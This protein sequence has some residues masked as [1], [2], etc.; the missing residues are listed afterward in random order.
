M[1]TFKYDRGMLLVGTAGINLKT[2][3]IKAALV[4]A[5]YS[6]SKSADGFVSDIPAA[7]LLARS[8][9]LT[10][11][12]IVGGVFKGTIPQFSALLLVSPASGLVLYQEGGNDATSALLYY[13]N[14]GIGFPFTANGINYFIGYD[15]ANGGWFQL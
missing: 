13:S 7:A 11:T 14:D 6:A 9:Q 12:D 2:A 8:A 1:A 10:G 5:A 3:V 4:S 15:Q